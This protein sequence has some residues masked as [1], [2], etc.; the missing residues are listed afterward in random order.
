MSL[1]TPDFGLIFWMTLIF[2]AVF[3]ILAKF[4]FPVITGMVGKRRE[5]INDGIRLAKEAE[6][7]MKELELRQE[8]MLQ[9]ARAEQGRILKEAAA[10]RDEIIAKAKT[11]ASQE[12]SRIL[13]SAKVQL[14][15]EKEGVLRDIRSQVALL[16][17]KVAEKVVRK[18]LESTT[19]RDAFL[20]RMVDELSRTDLS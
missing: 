7:K 12:A 14:E 2:A 10:T 6:E 1:I 5:R 19:E 8:K 9:E 11:E 4:G 20:D 13:E 15:A 17:V 3:F 18:D 16:S